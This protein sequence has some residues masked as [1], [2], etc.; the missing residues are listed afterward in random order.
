MKKT[1]TLFAVAMLLSGWLIAQ[2]K[3]PMVTDRPDQTESASIVTLN[4]FQI[5]TGFSFERYNSDINNTTYNST[6]VRYGLCEKIELRLGLAY[7]GTNIS[8]DGGSFD[9]SGFAPIVVGAKFQLNEES[10]GL[11]KL[12]LMTTFSLPNTGANVYEN[13]YLGA[14]F[15]VNGEYS[16]NEAMSLGANLGVAWSGAEA[17]N[18]AVGV[19]TAVIGMSLSEK[20]GAFAELYGFLPKDGKNDHRWDAGMT[21]SVNEDLQLDFATGIGLS[22]VSPDFFVSLGLSIRMP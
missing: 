16:L 14:D 10:E 7:L 6:L 15:R 13:K 22:K 8:F 18:T 11:P 4:G 12:A 17:G 20:L 1:L 9:E 2:E 19:Y 3:A 5:E 21:Y